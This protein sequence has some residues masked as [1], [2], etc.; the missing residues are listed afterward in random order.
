MTHLICCC[1]P[2]LGFDSTCSNT[3]FPIRLTTGNKNLG[4]LTLIFFTTLEHPRGY[5]GIMRSH[6]LI[7][8]LLSLHNLSQNDNISYHFESKLMET[9]GRINMAK[10][11]MSGTCSTWGTLLSSQ[12]HGSTQELQ[13]TRAPPFKDERRVG[14]AKWGQ[15]YQ[16]NSFKGNSEFKWKM[17]ERVVEFDNWGIMH[18]SLYW[19]QVITVKISKQ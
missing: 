2:L 4:A 9:P 13:R 8:P 5:L 6:S 14:K 16:G 12:Y 3:N 7:K 19:V 17:I 10:A 15:V 1:L 11:S 18:S